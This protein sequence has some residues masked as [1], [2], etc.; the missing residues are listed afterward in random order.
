[1]LEQYHVILAS[2]SPRR[3]ELL[4]GL[5]I[6]FEVKT[7]KG[8]EEHFPSHLR[9]GEIPLF[10]AKQ[11]MGAYSS[12]IQGNELIITA[13]TIVWHG[14]EVMGKPRDHEG[15]VQMLKKLSG[16]IHQVYT[17]V[18]VKTAGKEISFCTRS[19]VTFARLTD[20]EIEYYVSHYKPFDKAG[21]YGVQEWIGYIGV[22]RI[23]GSYFNI[24]GLPVQRLYTELLKF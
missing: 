2:N 6:E 14:D 20:Q 3:R 1:M 7:I 17:G 9:E 15:A 13:D 24:M 19:D 21:S 8:L 23:E 12:F 22:E 10:L 18:C 16:D 4:A 11:K 5:E